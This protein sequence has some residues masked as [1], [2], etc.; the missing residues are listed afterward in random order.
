MAKK[1]VNKDIVQRMITPVFRLSYPHLFKAQA[2]KPTDKPKFSITM[3]FPKGTD[4]MGQTLATEQEPSRPISL[5]DVIR[6]AKLQ[7]FGAQENWPKNLLSP[8]T[9]GDE[10]A[11]NEGYKGHWVIKATSN[12]E[13]RPGVVDAQGVPITEASVIYPGCYCRA[14]V[15][16]RV[17]EYMGKQGVQF[18][19]DHVQKMKD[20]KS[21]GGKKP[22]EQVFGPV[23]AGD[24]V[25]DEETESHDFM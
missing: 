10:K 18:I 6:N 17:W 1:P 11:E 14:Y 15:Y 2:P 16:A 22:V 7:E 19:L 8:V 20:G 25:A 12:E 24:D 5:K 13:S 3:L 23:S 4:L 21:F 9:D